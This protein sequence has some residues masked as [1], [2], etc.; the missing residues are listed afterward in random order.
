VPSKR[1]VLPS[2]FPGKKKEER[3]EGGVRILLPVEGGKRDN[4]S[5]LT[6]ARRRGGKLN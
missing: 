4:V 5:F 1:V 6:L 3:R 2:N